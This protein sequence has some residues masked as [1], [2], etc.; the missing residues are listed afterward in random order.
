MRRI[1]YSEFTLK[2]IVFDEEA[3]AKHALETGEIDKKP[4]LTLRAI[5][6]Y[7]HSIGKDKEEIRQE[8]EEFMSKNFPNYI[9]GKWDES[10]D[11]L[12]NANTKDNIKMNKIECVNI[13]EKELEYINGLNDIRLERVAFVILVY[14]KIK[15]QISNSASP[16][17]WINFKNSEVFKDAKVRIT[18]NEQSL[19]LHK[20]KNLGGIETCKIVGNSS[21]KILYINEESPTVIQIDDFREIV[22]NYLKWKGEPIKR[23]IEC[24]VL[25]KST[26]TKGR[27]RTMCTGC[28][29]D[30]DKLKKKKW[31]Q[32]NKQS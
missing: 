18:T 8:I 3:K 17:A 21:R 11:M 28:Q 16:D 27:P 14:Y 10:L 15:R 22:L 30:K 29:K 2:N 23:C 31:W 26:Q 9:S 4:V 13:T 6:R 7:L 19:M 25:F 1:R 24:G 12:V 32:E 20:L 5:V